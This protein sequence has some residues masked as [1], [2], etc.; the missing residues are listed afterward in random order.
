MQQLETTMKVFR[1]LLSILSAHVLFT[2]GILGQRSW[3]MNH[4]EGFS[5]A[6]D[7]NPNTPPMPPT[8]NSRVKKFV[9]DTKNKLWDVDEVIFKI[10]SLSITCL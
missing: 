10:T 9:L 5:L 6:E 4:F 1:Q 2:N 8:Q 3:C 7:Y